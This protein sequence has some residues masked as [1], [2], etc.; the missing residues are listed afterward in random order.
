[1]ATKI[2][3]GQVCLLQVT[4]HGPGG[5]FVVFFANEGELRERRWDAVQVAVMP[6]APPG[7]E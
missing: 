5:T 1:M 4:P 3:A 7:A 2:E 6:G